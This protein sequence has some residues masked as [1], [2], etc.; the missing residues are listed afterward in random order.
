MGIKGVAFWLNRNR[1]RSHNDPALCTSTVH[2]TLTREADAGT[3]SCD[4]C[5]SQTLKPRPIGMGSH[6]CPGTVPA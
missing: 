2:T 1:D 3:W 6:T 5:D 4:T